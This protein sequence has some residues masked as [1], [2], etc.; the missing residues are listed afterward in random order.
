VKTLKININFWLTISEKH[1]HRNCVCLKSDMG[2]YLLFYSSLWQI[3]KAAHERRIMFCRQASYPKKELFLGECIFVWER[4]LHLSRSY[5]VVCRIFPTYGTPF[6][7]YHFSTK[8]INLIHVTKH[9]NVVKLIIQDSRHCP[10]TIKGVLF[11]ILVLT[12][13]TVLFESCSWNCCYSLFCA[14]FK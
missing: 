9:C 2:T 13:K 12:N 10:T 6:L 5:W 14:N 7:T 1:P 4:P 3:V 8:Y 11:L